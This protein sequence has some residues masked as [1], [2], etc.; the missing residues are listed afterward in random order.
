MPRWASTPRLYRIGSVEEEEEEAR[1][2]QKSAAIQISEHRRRDDSSPTS[3]RRLPLPPSLARRRCRGCGGGGGCSAICAMCGV[4][5]LQ[6]FKFSSFARAP[7][8][9]LRAI[10]MYTFC[11]TFALFGPTR[12]TLF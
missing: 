5:L 3:S 9:E 7:P 8:S 12:R 6:T 11:P 4:C 2:V 1:Y 10:T